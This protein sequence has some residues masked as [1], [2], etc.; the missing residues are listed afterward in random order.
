MEHKII[1]MIYKLNFVALLKAESVAELVDDLRE[2]RYHDRVVN[3][4]RDGQTLLNVENRE[5]GLV[6]VYERLNDDEWEK[7][8][9][10]YKRI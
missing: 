7:D 8:G 5:N 6:E 3:E 9:D 4:F 10:T 1:I 2:I